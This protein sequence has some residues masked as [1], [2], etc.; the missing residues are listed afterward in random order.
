ML[1]I[2]PNFPKQECVGDCFYFAGD[3]FESYLYD[4]KAIA[5]FI[6]QSNHIIPTIMKKQ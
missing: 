3:C 4:C 2:C 6:M 1:V 5:L